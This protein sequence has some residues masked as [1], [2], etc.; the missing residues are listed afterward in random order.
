MFVALSG[1]CRVAAG[2]GHVESVCSMAMADHDPN[3][4]PLFLPAKVARRL[5]R[6]ADNERGARAD[7][8]RFFPPPRVA[9]REG[10]LCLGGELAPEWLMDAY[11]HG[12]FPWPMWD[13][14]PVPWWSPDPRAIIELDELHVSRRLGRTMRSGRFEVTSDRDFAG[15]MRGCAEGPQRRG[16]TWL[17]PEM[18]AAYHRL[19]LL[20]HAHSVEAW[21]EGRLVGGI[22][23][24]AIGGLFAAESMFYSERDASKVAL[25]RLVLHLRARGY[26][27]L[28]VQQW[29]PHTG[30]LG[31]VEIPREEYLDRLRR[32]VRMDVSFGETLAGWPSLGIAQE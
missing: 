10:L 28:D 24:V 11:S 1:G 13:D 12:I 20:G 27:L 30:R 8:P 3:A 29:T 15:V 14:E 32:A 26:A 4:A 16:G 25:V 21:H 2:R 31:A 17:T 6:L 9:L 5:E 7:W 22:Y 19:H 23:G 18:M